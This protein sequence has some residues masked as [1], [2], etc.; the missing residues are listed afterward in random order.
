MNP[1][2]SYA[3]FLV[4]NAES[5]S[6][7]IVDYNLGK[8]EIELPIEIVEKSINTNKEFLV[9]LGN[10][11]YLSNETVREKFIEWHKKNTDQTEYD[12]S[13][14]D[15]SRLIKPYADTRL[16]LTEMLTKISKNEGLSLE[17]VVQVNNRLSYLLD[18]SI[19][20]T[21]IDRERLANENNKKNQKIIT[22]LSSPIVPLQNG[23]AIL[24]LIGEIDLDRYEHIMN[25]VI[26]KVNE[27][28]TNCLIIDFS[29]IAKIDSDVARRI[30][31]IN[32]VLGLI[33]V[34]TMFTGIR[35]ELAVSI[36]SAGIDFSSFQT[37]GTV[38]QAILNM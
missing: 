32:D 14:D 25:S 22:E 30:F 10:S 28:N 21:M 19:T 4:Q 9:F 31:T 20:E 12:F 33:G 24:P 18:L 16:H 37:F 35:P 8:L 17:E 36:I 27:L 6:K 23:L 7:E 29:G 3:Q 13:F 38:Q 1:I 11:L 34:N 15:I 2:E 26:P 5:I